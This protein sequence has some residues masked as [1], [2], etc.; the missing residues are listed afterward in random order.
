VGRYTHPTGWGFIRFPWARQLDADIDT[1]L[2]EITVELPTWRIYTDAHPD[3]AKAAARERGVMVS[4][5]PN[6]TAVHGHTEVVCDTLNAA[7]VTQAALL[8]LGFTAHA[9]K[10][11]P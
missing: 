4:A 2:K 3:T 1:A 11:K 9:V 6:R 10:V 5:G 8:G 7:Q